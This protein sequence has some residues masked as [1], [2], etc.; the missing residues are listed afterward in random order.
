LVALHFTSSGISLATLFI[1]SSLNPISAAFIKVQTVRK[2]RAIQLNYSFTDDLQYY[3]ITLR[4]EEV[5]LLCVYLDETLVVALDKTE[6]SGELCNVSYYLSIQLFVPE[7][8]AIANAK[9]SKTSITY[10]IF[11]Y[12]PFLFHK[13]K[14]SI[15]SFNG[16]CGVGLGGIV[17]LDISGISTYL[18]VNC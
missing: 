2:F 6:M 15:L 3:C 16:G 8:L 5:V 7:S 11:F 18:Y 4:C 17:G 13:Q 12:I 14:L 10:L 9:I 1:K